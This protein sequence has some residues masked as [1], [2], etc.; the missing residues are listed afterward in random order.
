KNK[1]ANHIYDN[2]LFLRKHH[3]RTPAQILPSFQ[4]L[5]D[6]RADKERRTDKA[7]HMK[8][9]KVKHLVYAKPRSSFAF[10]HGHTK[11]N[12]QSKIYKTTHNQLKMRGNTT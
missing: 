2:G 8:R 1:A 11:Y 4:Q 9:L 12:A 10:I 3:H 5:R 6:N 7:V